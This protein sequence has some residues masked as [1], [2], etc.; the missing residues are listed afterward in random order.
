MK[1]LK[2]LCSEDEQSRTCWMAAFR[3]FKVSPSWRALGGTGR[4]WSD[5]EEKLVGH[6]GMLEGCWWGAGGQWVRL[7]D[8]EVYW[9]ALGRQRGVFTPPLPPG[10]PPVWHAAL[11]QL[12]ASAGTPEPAPLDHP[13]TTGECPPPPPGAA[14]IHGVPPT[15]LSSLSLSPQQSVSDSA[16]V[17]MD[18]S[19]CTGRVIENPSEVLTAVLE[20]A[21]AWRVSGGARAGSG[22][23]PQRA[24]TLLF[25][26]H[27]Q[28]KTTHRYSLPAA[29]QSS[30]LSAGEQRP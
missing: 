15:P 6:S 11:P 1:G 29:C 13:N 24:L 16:L 28:K 25:S 2:L 22:T 23:P 3:L 21:Q 7:G 12:P 17:A 10:T 5:A 26:L 20:E 9:E 19:G 30:P 27:G 4:H 8:A 14:P 18:F